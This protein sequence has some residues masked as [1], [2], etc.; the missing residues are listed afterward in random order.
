MQHLHVTVQHRLVGQQTVA[1]VAGAVP[2]CLILATSF[3]F[4]QCGDIAQHFLCTTAVAKNNTWRVQVRI[5]EVTPRNTCKR[6]HHQ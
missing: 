1:P 6:S 2:A 4:N 5:T 3:F